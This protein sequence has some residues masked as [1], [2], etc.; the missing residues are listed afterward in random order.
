MDDEGK[1]YRTEDSV[2]VSA[3]N[4][5]GSLSMDGVTCI[6]PNAPAEER[7]YQKKFFKKQ[8]YLPDEY[9][10][11]IKN[12]VEHPDKFVV[13]MNGYTTITDEQAKRYGV[14]VGAYE[15]ACTAVLDEIVEHIKTK[16]KGAE[17]KLVHG[18]TYLGVDGAIQE[19]ATKH[20]IVPLGFSCP[21]FMLYVDDDEVPVYVGRDKKEYADKFI[22]SLDFL[23]AT[24]GREQALQHDVLAACIYNKRIHFVDVLNSLSATGGVPATITDE[25]GRTKVDNAAAA[26]GRNLS[27]FSYQDAV[28]ARPID[29]DVWDAIFSNVKSIATEVC[30]HK[31]SPA[32]KF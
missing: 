19:V 3:L 20:N 11:A 10:K 15:K 17:L 6:N 8:I 1:I 31:M 26:M 30:R 18:A 29:G 25:N 32:R 12:H 2:V 16:F 9:D 14:Q 13:S 24:G 27:F 4:E 23:V 22:E 5:P 7:E 21:K 28:R